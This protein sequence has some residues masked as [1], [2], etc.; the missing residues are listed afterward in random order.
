MNDPQTAA[1]LQTMLLDL[2][3]LVEFAQA[4]VLEEIKDQIEEL[5][6][7]S[8]AGQAPHSPPPKAPYKNSW[9][10]M[11]IRVDEKRMRVRGGVFSLATAEDGE[12]LAYYLENGNAVTKARPHTD[13]G[14]IGA[15]AAVETRTREISSR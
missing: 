10:E 13:K 4:E 7:P 2:V 14:V 8:E 3:P 12:S 15:R 6:F 11:R 1:V 5:D 9:K